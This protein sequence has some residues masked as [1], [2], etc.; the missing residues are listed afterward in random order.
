MRLN[1][2]FLVGLLV[3]GA[4]N[5]QS[6]VKDHDVKYRLAINEDGRLVHETRRQSYGFR[7]EI[8]SDNEGVKTEAFKNGR[9]FVTA[10]KGENYSV[11]L[12]NPLPVRVAVNLTVDGLNSITGKPSGITDGSKWMID[13]YSSVTIPGWQVSGG[14]ARR[15][16]FTDKP[17]SYAKWEGDE[18]GKDLSANCG[19]IGAAYFWNQRELDEYYDSHPLYRYTQR[20]YPY[21]TKAQSL[22]S[23]SGASAAAP[24][25]EAMNREMNRADMKKMEEPQEQAGTGM[26]EHQYHPTT[27][28]DFEFD[29]GMYSPSQAL[30]I[31]YD[32]AKVQTPNP[33]PAIG[34]AP[35][36]P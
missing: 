17:K 6:A 16:F 1:K 7:V 19:V 21:S 12:Y 29:R 33:F 8:V 26:G 18:M 11:R 15:F 10:S 36:M 2:M 20:P 34:Y 4:S 3:L 22:D 27:Q 28:V 25:P 14:D 5:A 35:E 31:Y 13:P 30:V 24:A 23:M 32:F 9:P